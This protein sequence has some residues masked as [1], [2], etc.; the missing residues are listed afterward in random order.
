MLCCSD[1]SLCSDKGTVFEVYR[2]VIK[3]RDPQKDDYW[4]GSSSFKTPHDVFLH[5]CGSARL[6]ICNAFRLRGV[7]KVVRPFLG[8]FEQSF[9]RAASKHLRI[10][11]QDQT[12]TSALS[13]TKPGYQICIHHNVST[14]NFNAS[15]V[16]RREPMNR[17]QRPFNTKCEIYGSSIGVQ[18]ACICFTSAA[19][20]ATSNIVS[21][22]DNQA[23]IRATV[24]TRRRAR[25]MGRKNQMLIQKENN[26]SALK[27]T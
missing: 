4:H 23:R 17:D 5:C 15:I 12:V 26:R 9:D 6:N 2:A 21:P 14:G 13:S 22:F 11:N 24:S 8:P 7:L 18:N 1:G 19:A 20:S 10:M 27:S 16:F 3:D 25:L